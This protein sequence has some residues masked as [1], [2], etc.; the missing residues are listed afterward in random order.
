MGFKTKETANNTPSKHEVD[1]LIFTD[2]SAFYSLKNLDMNAKHLVD[3]IKSGSL[4][5]EEFFS[6]FDK[7]K[8]KVKETYVD[9]AENLE[10]IFG[11]I[12]E[13]IAINDPEYFMTEIRFVD[14]FYS[15]ID[16]E[17]FDD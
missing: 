17:F 6:R 13:L 1:G 12:T 16:I 4:N 8:V 3:L 15:L 7:I 11:N 9:A 10:N 5:I 2:R 14:Y